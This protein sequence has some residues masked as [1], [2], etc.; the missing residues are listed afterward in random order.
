MLPK[1]R[2]LPQ[3]SVRISDMHASFIYQRQYEVLLRSTGHLKRDGLW[4]SDDTGSFH[5]YRESEPAAVSELFPFTFPSYEANGSG[6]FPG[7]PRPGQFRVSINRG[8]DSSLYY[9]SAADRPLPEVV[10]PDFGDYVLELNAQ[11]TAFI[12]RARPGNPTANLFQFV[13]ELREIPLLPRLRYLGLKSFRDLGENYLNYEFGWKPFVK[14]LVD[15]YKTQL[16]LEATLQK[17]RDNNGLVVRRREKK[18][19]STSSSDICEGSLSVPFGHLGDTAI[20]GNSQLNGFYVSGPTGSADLDLYSFSGQCD[21]SYTTI[22]TLTTWNCGNFGYYVPDIGSS[23]WTERAKR[24]LFGQN[25]T[26]SQLWELIPWSWLIDWFSNVGDIM[27]NISVNAVD[28]EVWTNCFSMKEI[29]LEHEIVISTHWDYL[30]TEPFGSV[31][32]VPAGAA[33]VRYVRTELNKLRRQASP[34]GF[35]LD[36]PNFSPRQILILA[37]LTITR[38]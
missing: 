31:F 15:M 16:K 1:R 13:G 25:P 12:K 27:S 20:G 8:Y 18:K 23:Q 4:L 9:G 2:N 24:A 28:N 3:A 22:E 37:A 6:D 38:G 7:D 36:W 19:T 32:E 33:S 5:V 26:P 10:E 30:Y 11:G 35:G 34:Y 21:Y 29:T 17:L 14:D